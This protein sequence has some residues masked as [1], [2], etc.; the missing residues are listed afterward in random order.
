MISQSVLF[1]KFYQGLRAFAKENLTNK[2]RFGVETVNML[3]FGDFAD[4]EII[5]KNLF[6]P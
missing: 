5:A 4:L 6:N 1:V 3:F 2:K